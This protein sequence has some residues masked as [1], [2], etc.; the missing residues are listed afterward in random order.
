MLCKLLLLLISISFT[1]AEVCKYPG[2]YLL[3]Q[4]ELDGG[5]A[6]FYKNRQK[7]GEFMDERQYKTVYKDKYM[8]LNIVEDRMHCMDFV[9]MSKVFELSLKQCHCLQTIDRKFYPPFRIYLQDSGSGW[10]MFRFDHD[11]ETRYYSDSSFPILL[12]YTNARA[13]CYCDHPHEAEIERYRLNNKPQS[14]D[15]QVA[16]T[17]CILSFI[18]YTEIVYPCQFSSNKA[19]LVDKGRAKYFPSIS[20]LEKET[21]AKHIYIFSLDYNDP[22]L[23]EHGGL[24]LKLAR[25]MTKMFSCTVIITITNMSGLVKFPKNFVKVRC[26]GIENGSGFC[27]HNYVN[28]ETFW[29][30]GYTVKPLTTHHT[31]NNTMYI[32]YLGYSGVPKDLSCEL[33][34]ICVDG[35]F[36]K[37]KHVVYVLIKSLAI[38]Q[39]TAVKDVKCPSSKTY[40]ATIIPLSVDMVSWP[41]NHKWVTTTVLPTHVPCCN[42][43]GWRFCRRKQIPCPTAEIVEEKI[44]KHPFHCFEPQPGF[45]KLVT[46]RYWEYF[47]KD[48]TRHNR[49][50][51]YQFDI[52]E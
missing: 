37:L 43:G 18:P 48:K 23:E 6:W 2:D 20:L 40:N 50:V 47:I 16:L 22:K 30:L 52:K 21:L 13:K 31:I 25:E 32:P 4:L 14:K 34:G 19:I 10:E 7:L 33:F 44:I 49:L 39:T 5:D 11:T 45:K 35:D 24:L 28:V 26:F 29:Q 42:T 38:V 1:L 8:D 36:Q 3:E 12:G 51:G 9:W 17:K 46:E 41:N 27:L 15:K